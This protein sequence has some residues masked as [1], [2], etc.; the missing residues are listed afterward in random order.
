[1]LWSLQKLYFLRSRL[2]YSTHI[3]KCID[4]LYKHSLAD[5]ICHLSLTIFAYKA[6]I[7]HLGYDYGEMT[8][9]RWFWWDDFLEMI[10]MRWLLEMILMRWLLEMTLRWL[11][12]DDFDEMTATDDFDKM[13]STDG[14]DHM[15]F[16]RWF[17]MRW[18][19]GD[20]FGWDDFLALLAK[21]HR[22]F[23]FWWFFS[24]H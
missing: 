24:L 5:T 19:L 17:W 10:L 12:W 7:I 22:I 21:I 11:W 16:G 6:S 8:F 23:K 13:T 20:D 1:M 3:L 14:F 2:T 9:S 4:I 15:T 18:L